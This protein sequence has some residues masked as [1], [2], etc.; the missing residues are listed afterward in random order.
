MTIT[1]DP[2]SRVASWVAVGFKPLPIPAVTSQISEFWKLEPVQQLNTLRSAYHYLS[3]VKG[4]DRRVLEGVERLAETLERELE[5]PLTA[6]MTVANLEMAWIRHQ[7]SLSEPPDSSK[8]VVDRESMIRAAEQLSKITSRP[9]PPPPARHSSVP[10]S[11][12]VRGEME[13]LIKWLDE[14]VG[15]LTSGTSS[16]MDIRKYNALLTHIFSTVQDGFS[17]NQQKSFWK[18]IAFRDDVHQYF[19]RLLRRD[20]VKAFPTKA[21]LQMTYDVAFRFYSGYLVYSLAP[22]AEE[23]AASFGSEEE[24]RSLAQN[25]SPELIHLPHSVGGSLSVE[26]KRALKVA[27]GILTRLAREAHNPN[28]PLIRAFVLKSLKGDLERL[29]TIARILLKHSRR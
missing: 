7:E 17:K 25:L 11:Q 20:L 19:D 16:S 14:L 9:P 4:V 29:P 5:L 22:L 18:E 28:S 10:P 15:L 12:Q 3:P 8:V 26:A 13:N 27:D 6:S 24:G 2:L 1:I 21:D 23:P